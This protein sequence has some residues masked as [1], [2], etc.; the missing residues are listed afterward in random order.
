VTRISGPEKF[1]LGLVAGSLFGAFCFYTHLVVEALNRRARRT[2]HDVRVDTVASLASETIIRAEHNGEETL[3]YLADGRVAVV[4][5]H[6][7]HHEIYERPPEAG[8]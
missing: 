2:A 7:R 1:A 8:K 5:S 6:K 4:R 3:L